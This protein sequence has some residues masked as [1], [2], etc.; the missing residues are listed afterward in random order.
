MMDLTAIEKDEH[1][2]SEYIKQYEEEMMTA[3]Q[4]KHNLFHN[5]NQLAIGGSGTNKHTGGGGA[6]RVIGDSYS[7][8][9]NSYAGSD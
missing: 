3:G 6:P 7:S 8:F 9:I 1:C 4:K 2:F 5:H